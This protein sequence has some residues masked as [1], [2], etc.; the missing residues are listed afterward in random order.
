MNGS[1][2]PRILIVLTTMALGCAGWTQ[3]PARIETTLNV[4]LVS[5]YVW[6]GIVYVND[7]AVQP[8]VEFAWGQW[9][10]NLWGNLEP[11]DWN[12]NAYPSNPQGR[13][14][15]FDAT[16]E[17]AGVWQGGT[18]R[19]SVVDYRFPV[20]GWSPYRE[21][22]VAIARET[23]AG[24]AEIELT[25]ELGSKTGTSL[26]LV[27][28]KSVPFG[29]ERSLDVE[30][31]AAYGDAR[32]NGFLYAAPKSGFSFAGLHLSSTH[33]LGRGW[34]VTPALHFTT[35]V[36][37]AMLAGQPRRTNAWLGVSVSRKL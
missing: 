32:S 16:V 3:E 11:T 23:Q 14:T 36:D 31:E 7:W 24:A 35:L 13:F 21:W 19:A 30:A 5:K 26:R 1:T 33:D 34:S 20:T 4:D 2:R 18:W 8:S 12:R 28:S 37:R 17:Y 10:L 27:L 6:R 9:T 22:T 15:E 29:D 25:S